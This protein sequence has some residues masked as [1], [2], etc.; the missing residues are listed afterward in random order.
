M[1]GLNS[2]AQAIVT[3]GGKIPMALLVDMPGLSTP[4][5][6]CT[7]RWPLIW[8]GT[9]YTAVGTLGEVDAAQESSSGPRPLGFRLNGVPASMRALVLSENVQG[10]AVSVYLAIFDPA[11]YQIAD[12]VLEWDGLLDVMSW[13]DDGATGSITVSAESAGADLLRGVPVRYTD[14]DQQRLYPGDLGFQYV[15]DQGEK[16]ITWPAASY[17]RR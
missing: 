1:R 4:L 2:A 8:G 17:F 3:A 9:N 11:T 10:R 14:Q 15:I 13:Q 12:A 7:G 6:L 16:T 5:H